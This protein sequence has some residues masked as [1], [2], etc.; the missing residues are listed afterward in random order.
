MG[1]HNGN[2]VK[3]RKTFAPAVWGD[4]PCSCG[5]V[6]RPL[7][8]RALD[9]MGKLMLIVGLAVALIC[10]LNPGVA[11][12][13][14]TFSE[15]AYRQLADAD[16]PDTIPVGTKITLQNWQQYKKFLPVSFQAMFSGQYP[17]H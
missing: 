1:K 7:D 3:P 12:A 5:S 8:S 10:S 6:K 13:Q 2:L 15:D 17:R 11:R 14:L 9:A 16:S 4:R